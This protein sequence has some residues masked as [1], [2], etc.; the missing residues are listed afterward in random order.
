MQALY[1]GKEG[2][3]V[4]FLHSDLHTICRHLHA[5]WTE[6]LSYPSVRLLVGLL[7]VLCLPFPPNFVSEYFDQKRQIWKL[8]V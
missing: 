6:G 7:I 2:V 1:N 5:A 3:L 4:I 8:P